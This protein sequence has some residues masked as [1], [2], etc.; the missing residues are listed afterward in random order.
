M[1]ILRF[2]AVVG[3]LATS[4]T[5]VR[6]QEACSEDCPALEQ[7][8]IPPRVYLGTVQER[9]RVT[10][11]VA[12]DL[13]QITRISGALWCTD[14]SS[15]R[16]ELIPFAPTGP[17]AISAGKAGFAEVVETV[18]DV[19]F[20]YSLDATFAPNQLRGTLRVS[21]SSADTCD[22]GD[23]VFTALRQ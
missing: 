6:A 13:S 5:Y 21:A 22:T 9:Q 4:A 12:P 15:S 19:T 23:Q 1:R 11:E 8:V 20:T 14:S 16:T 18:G 2:I 3:L 7:P 10:I 17:F